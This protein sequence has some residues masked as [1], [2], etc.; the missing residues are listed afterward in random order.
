MSIDPLAEVVSLLR[1][2]APYA[3][4]SSGAG[5]WR[6]RR[7]DATTSFY[8]AILEGHYRL[9]IDGQEPMI[10]TS[11]DFVLVPAN[12]DFAATSLEP[13]DPGLPDRHTVLADGE[14]RL[15]DPD[16]VV[17]ARMLVGHCHFASADAALLVSL[18]P[19]HIR[20]HGE[21]RLTTLM[22]LLRDE[23]RHRRP[24]REMVLVRLTEVLL[25]EALRSSSSSTSAPGLVRGLADERIGAALRHMH[26]APANDWSISRLA[27]AAA[28]SRSGFF[29]RF[30]QMVGLP[31]MEYLLAWRM[32]MARE[33]LC[34]GDSV[35]DVAEQVG[36]S[37]ASTFSVAF[38]R[39][40][41]LPPGRYA[42]TRQPV[43]P[44]IG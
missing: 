20:L 40:V 3:K 15:G 6:V 27:T 2:G 38:S 19:G 10:L 41:G 17:N 28:M 31:P 36:Y 33:R 4:L 9:C 39:H 43:A 8:C 13:P 30:T 35:A 21:E 18:L 23:S 16:G 26:S 32:A 5:R 7:T 12:L 29:Q 25:I 14:I 11:G 34:Q 24:A 42:R 22:A 1:P 37:S 44:P